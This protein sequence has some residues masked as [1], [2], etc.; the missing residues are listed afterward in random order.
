MKWKESNSGNSGVEAFPRD[1]IFKSFFA[2]GFECSTHRTRTGRRLDL[3]AATHHDQFALQDYQRLQKQGLRVAREGLR[4]HLVE[5]TPGRYDFSTALPIVRAA[6]ATG[7]QV[8]WD[9]CHFG[10]PDYLDIFKPEFVSALAGYAAASA[11]WLSKETDAPGFFVPVNEISFF[12]WAA[13]DEGSIFPFATRRGFELK[14]HLVRAAIQAMDGIW[15]VMPDARFVHVDPI[16]HVIAALKRP[17]DKP[18]AEAYRL[19]QFQSWDML[20]GR[21][22]PELG[23]HEKYLDII[24]VNF[25]PHNQWF[26]NL[27]GFRRIRRFTPIS[28]HHPSYRPF[29]EMLAEVYERYRRPMF[30]AE[31]GSENRIRARWLRYVGKETQAAIARGIPVHG[32]CLYPILN[33]PGWLDNRHC[34]NGLWDYPDKNGNRKIYEP[35]ARELRRWQKVFENSNRQAAEDHEVEAAAA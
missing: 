20:S 12:S 29:R 10:W 9:L 19:S 3:V 24:G 31:T 2:G 33:H 35:L 13:G 16:I 1:P 27:K 8:V 23:G 30:I 5:Q 6:R 17:E 18:D 34:H 4:W 14:T 28:R 21:M 7:T 11:K 26:Y 15:S 25:Y 22:L 32:M